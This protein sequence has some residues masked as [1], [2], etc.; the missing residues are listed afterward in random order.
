M[1]GNKNTLFRDLGEDDTYVGGLEGSNEIEG[2]VDVE[3]VSFI[4]AKK[5][6]EQ[7]QRAKR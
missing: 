1:T 6:F 7:L 2:G 4:R 5:K 3:A